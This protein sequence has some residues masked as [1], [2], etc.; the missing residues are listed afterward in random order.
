MEFIDSIGVVIDKLMPTGQKLG[1]VFNSWFGHACICSAIAYITNLPNLKLKTQPKKLLGSLLF[2][3]TLLSVEEP[4]QT[5][6]IL[7]YTTITMSLPCFS[8]HPF[9][10]CAEKP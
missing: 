6:L 9:L 1:L 7:L 3:V 4:C 8:F 5:W 10:Q 2:A